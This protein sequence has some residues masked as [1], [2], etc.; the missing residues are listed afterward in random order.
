MKPRGKQGEFWEEIN[1]VLW[2]E[3]DPISVGKHEWIRDEYK[4]YVPSIFKLLIQ[5]ESAT[6]IAYR[7]NE[8]ARVSMG[9]HPDSEHNLAIA[10]RLIILKEQFI[11]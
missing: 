3:W 1:R 9:L 10:K 5:N 6:I 2:E 11:G 7:L 8:H 4:S